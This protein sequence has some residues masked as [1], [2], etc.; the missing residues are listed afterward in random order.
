MMFKIDFNL[1]FQF[2][3]LFMF[4]TKEGSTIFHL[5]AKHVNDLKNE[6]INN[7]HLSI[8]ELDLNRPIGTLINIPSNKYE[9]SKIESTKYELNRF[10][11]IKNN[12][13]KYDSTA[14]SPTSS[15]ASS[16]KSSLNESSLSDSTQTNSG[17]F[18]SLNEHVQK[19]IENDQILGKKF[20]QISRNQ[21]P[22]LNIKK[23][24]EGLNSLP[25]VQK[26]A[27]IEEN[28]IE[29]INH[30]NPFLIHFENE[31]KTDLNEINSKFNKPM[32]EINNLIKELH[33]NV[34]KQKIDE[35]E[36]NDV[37]LGSNLV[38]QMNNKLSSCSVV[39]LIEDKKLGNFNKLNKSLPQIDKL[40]INANVDSKF[41]SKI[42][43]QINLQIT[44]TNA[45][46]SPKFNTEINTAINQI[47]KANYSNKITS[48]MVN[49]LPA[50]KPLILS[51][52]PNVLIKPPRLS[53]ML[54]NDESNKINERDAQKEEPIFES[55]LDLF[56]Y[57]KEENHYEIAD[58]NENN[59]NQIEKISSINLTT[60]NQTNSDQQNDSYLASKQIRSSESTNNLLP[61]D[62]Y[63]M[64]VSTLNKIDE[65]SLNTLKEAIKRVLNEN[66]SINNKTEDEFLKNFLLTNN[67]Q[68][69]MVNYCVNDCEYAK[70]MKKKLIKKT[71]VEH[72]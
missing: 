19:G 6:C 4:Y 43:S 46:V 45:K 27:D 48:E 11:L 2:L 10:N 1:L 41:S 66:P 62:T 13:S 68:E 55:R 59:E 28:R 60:K 61:I 71:I 64:L 16:I 22:A 57:K 21:K 38:K 72:F 70:I 37:A 36:Y 32:N 18:T 12:S 9:S 24:N 65:K 44:S 47:D 54:N 8:K 17:D 30:N 69:T 56:G 7:N 67:N 23:T 42:N 5:L 3:G 51:H 53:K 25:V 49:N 34:P 50:E 26:R 29:K 63:K 58:D 20:N 33:K 35:D 31:I 39:N 52:Q 14:N 40:G 15:N